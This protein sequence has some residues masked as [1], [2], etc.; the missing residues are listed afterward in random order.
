MR[1]CVGPLRSKRIW[2]V[3]LGR[4]GGA[5]KR[6]DLKEIEGLGHA[7]FVESGAQRFDEGIDIFGEEELAVTADAAGVI[8]QSNEAGLEGRALVLNVRADERVGLPH[9]IGLSFGEGQPQFAGAVRIGF[10]QFVSLDDAAKG[11]R[12]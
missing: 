9:F 8:E 10:E 2:M 3:R 11:V 7:A 12:S 5:S 6:M 4:W 1:R